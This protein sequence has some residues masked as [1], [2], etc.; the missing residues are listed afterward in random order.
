MAKPTPIKQSSQLKKLLLLGAGLV[1]IVLVAF[2]SG[3]PATKTSTTGPKLNLSSGPGKSSTKK[4]DPYHTPAD[5]RAQ[6]E[7]FERIGATI[8]NGFVPGIGKGDGNLEAGTIPGSFTGGEGSWTYTGNMVVDGTP[9]A[10]LENGT[11]GDGVF[12][13]P[14]QTWKNC[15][16][17]AVKED[18]IELEGPNGLRK[19]VFFNDKSLNAVS[20]STSLQPLPPAAIQGNIPNNGMNPQFGQPNGGQGGGRRNRG[21]QADQ[22]NT[23]AMVGPIGSSDNLTSSLDDQVQTNN[24]NTNRNNRRIGRNQ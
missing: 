13:R 23:D 9:N 12:L 11:T 20:P 6:E 1:V 24:S 5:D 21:P 19:T 16:L 8:K 10:L 18:S 7:K 17:V 4:V 22:S 14:G 15:R 2:P 3:A